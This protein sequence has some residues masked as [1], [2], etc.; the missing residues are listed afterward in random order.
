MRVMVSA[1]PPL[2][3]AGAAFL[4]AGT[5]LALARPGGWRG[6]EV[7][8]V[9]AAGGVGLCLLGAQGLAT[10]AVVH[11]P[12]STAALVAAVIPLWVAVLRAV[13][14]E[15]LDAAAGARLGL[16]FAGVTVVVL[17]SSGTGNAAGPNGAA[18]AGWALVVAVG[19][20]VWAVGTVWASRSRHLPAPGV[21]AA[22]QLLTGG[23]VLL[24]TGTVVERP[25][26]VTVTVPAA[27]AF[28]ALVLLDSLGGFA[29][30]SWLVRRAPIGLVST[31]AYAVPVVATVVAVVGLGEPFH[32]LGLLGAAAILAAVAGEVRGGSGRADTGGG[33]RRR[34]HR[35]ASSRA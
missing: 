16:G 33:L 9:R 12:A 18:Q 21:A 4:T 10:L 22:I 7:R 31:Y 34:R 29:L 35:S 23:T 8:Q 1:L 2:T 30:Y 24:V 26:A 3:S 17:A 28:A 11:V 5:L 25:A 6:L 20:L 32:P 19:A 27:L 15:R 13:T 14:G